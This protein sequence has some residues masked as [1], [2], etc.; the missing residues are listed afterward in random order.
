MRK[1]RQIFQRLFLLKTSQAPLRTARQAPEV[2]GSYVFSLRATH[3]SLWAAKFEKVEKWPFLDPKIVFGQQNDF[4]GQ[5]GSRDL[6]LYH[7]VRA[8]CKISG[9]SLGPFS[10]SYSELTIALCCQTRARAG[11]PTPP[12]KFKRTVGLR[13]LGSGP[14][15]LWV[16]RD[17]WRKR[18]QPR[19]PT[20][21]ERGPFDVAARSSS[22]SLRCAPLRLSAMT[23]GGPPVSRLCL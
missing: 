9:K 1:K 22:H 2:F 8:A 7:R 18:G 19:H 17:L 14:R 5:N 4:S 6:F 11:G 15:G 16:F 10:R 23:Y 13:H 12:S 21:G 20:F 3:V